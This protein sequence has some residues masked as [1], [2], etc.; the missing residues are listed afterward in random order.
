MYFKDHNPPHFHAKEGGD[1][2]V[3]DFE[4]NTIKGKISPKKS[5]KV[6]KWAEENRSFLEDQWDEFQK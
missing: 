4:G 6:K 1:E 5:K 2:A 3:Y